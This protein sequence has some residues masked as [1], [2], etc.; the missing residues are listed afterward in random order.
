M[1][2]HQPE[3]KT[4][5]GQ[6]ADRVL[7]RIHYKYLHRFSECR[8]VD[9]A[10]NNNLAGSLSHPL[11][12]PRNARYI[13]WLSQLV[14]PQS[15]PEGG[16]HLLILLSGPEPQRTMLAD[17]L[18]AQ[19]CMLKIPVVF[20]EG[21]AL[22]ARRDIPAHIKHHGQVAGAALQALLEDASIIVCRSGYSTLMDLILLRKKAI[23]IPTPGQTEQEYLARTLA[24]RGMFF[25]IPQK[26]FSLALALAA[27]GGF[28]FHLP[29][30][31]G[32]HEAFKDFLDSWV[33][34]LGV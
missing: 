25:A 4:G 1:L 31:S 2:T 5:I 14:Q 27:A 10:G 26:N 13:G 11:I 16:K 6:W 18:W 24:E 21:A 29:E 3:I 19:A 32:A 8:I 30:A 23:L 20:V 15:M 33:R 17:A 34:G 22:A 12:M 7:R 9:V 28:P